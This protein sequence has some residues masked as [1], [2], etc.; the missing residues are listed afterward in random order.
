M[1][2]L[3]EEY[4][5]LPSMQETK[6]SY[7]K[8]YETN[9]F[10]RNLVIETKK[11]KVQIG[12]TGDMLIDNKTGEQKGGAIAFYQEKVDTDRFVKL[13][14]TNIQQT[15]ELSKTAHKVF[16]YVCHELS[17]SINSDTFYFYVPDAIKFC[18]YRTKAPIYN[19][20][21]ELVNKQ[22]IAMSNRPNIWFINPAIM[23]NGNRLTL[24]NDYIRKDKETKAL[25]DGFKEA[26]KIP[27]RQSLK[28]KLNQDNAFIVKIEGGKDNR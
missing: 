15:F 14:T 11:R 26:I 9:P 24:V 17:K 28:A 18:G 8:K 1:S 25:A 21:K 13:Y 22:I 7:N 4:E 5:N 2:E 10:M 12:Q 27:K 23:F 3:N 6:V 16:T 20:F 19:G